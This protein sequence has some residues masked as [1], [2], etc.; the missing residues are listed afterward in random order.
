VRL[1]A[2]CIASLRGWMTLRIGRRSRY[3]PIGSIAP[4]HK[5]HIA[6]DAPS[7]YTEMGPRRTRVPDRVEAMAIVTPKICTTRCKLLSKPDFNSFGQAANHTLQKPRSS[8][9]RNAQT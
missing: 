9:N 3:R 5:T 4:R 1:S 8:H 2:R 7:S 6:P